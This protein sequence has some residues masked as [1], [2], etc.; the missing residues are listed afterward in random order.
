[1]DDEV[2]RLLARTRARREALNSRLKS[3]GEEE[4]EIR[5]PLK[6]KNRAVSCSE[7]STES[8][9]PFKGRIL[10]KEVTRTTEETVETRR[11]VTFAGDLD[12]ET[13][14]D[15]RTALGDDVHE[16]PVVSLQKSVVPKEK[17]VSPLFEDDKEARKKRLAGLAAKYSAWEEELPSQ[18]NATAATAPA[19]TSE[20]VD[21]DSAI[22]EAEDTASSSKVK[23]S[24]TASSSQDPSFLKSLQAQGFTESSSK[25]KLVYDFN[26]HRR[27]S[28]SLSPVK[29]Y[30]TV[31]HYLSPTRSYRSQVPT[32]SPSPSKPHPL[33][34]VSP[35]ARPPAPLAGPPKP[36]RTYATPAPEDASDTASRQT[37]HEKKML[38]ES[39]SPQKTKSS[40]DPALLSLSDRKALFERNKTAPKPIAR[41]GEAVTPAMLSKAAAA[42]TTVSAGG[43]AAWKRRTE[44]G[45]ERSKRLR[46]V[47]P[48]HPGVSRIEAQKKLFESGVK[49]GD[50]R[51]TELARATEEKKKKDMDVL[52]KR[53]IS[54]GQNEKAQKTKDVKQKEE[55]ILEELPPPPPPPIPPPSPPQE[56]MEED[57]DTLEEHAVDE[58]DD[59]SMN[60]SAETTKMEDPSSPPLP[61]PPSSK[62]HHDNY[63]GIHS[64]KKVRISPP[65]SGNMYPQF[66]ETDE[67]TL[68]RSQT[69][70]SME[71]EAASEAPSLGTAIQQAA[72]AKRPSQ[73]SLIHEDGRSKLDSSNCSED[74]DDMLDEALDDSE[75]AYSDYEPTPP[76]L[77]KKSPTTSTSSWEFESKS[78]SSSSPRK[79]FKTPLISGLTDSP[80][81]EK[82]LPSIEGV[83]DGLLHTVSFYRKREPLP[84][85]VRNEAGS[86]SQNNIFNSETEEDPEI[87]RQ[88]ILLQIRKLQEDAMQQEQR[89]EQASKALNYCVSKDEFEGSSE[90]VEGERLLLEAFHKYS[91]AGAEVERLKTEG[92]MGKST[93]QRVRSMGC[94]GSISI[95]GISLRLKT[96]FIKLLNSGLDDF[97]HYFVC[98]VKYK[99]Q[100][101]ATQ[102]LSSVDGISKG[103]LHFPNLINVREL[104]FDFQIH[105]EVY[106]LQTRKEFFTHEAKYHIRKDKSVF[107]LTPLKKLKKQESSRLPGPRNQNPVNSKTIRRPA[108]G[109][110]GHTTISLDSMKAKKYSLHDVPP[111][112]PLEK[113]LLM[114]L[115]AHS[116]NKV[117]KRGFLT[118]FTDL[119]GY[120]D[121]NRRWCLLSGNTLKFWKYPE[122]ECK[123]VP[124]YEINLSSCITENVTLAP[125]EICSRMN[126]FMFETQRPT[127]GDDKQSLIMHVNSKSGLT[128]IRHLV[129][130]DTREERIAWCCIINSA[131]VNLRAWDPS[132]RPRTDSESSSTGEAASYRYTAGSVDSAPSTTDIW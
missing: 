120:G 95:S 7:S 74:I 106:A 119:N 68:P 60:D 112:S 72:A 15:L 34:F 53:F 21:V 13:K 12:E 55:I 127:R 51:E 116:E 30:P 5:S 56:E 45:E 61:T 121:W 87:L 37:L 94:K 17:S 41:F 109:R 132:F 92:A 47:S 111:I 99:S 82:S 113:D 10:K 105:L 90:R 83:K 100:V 4:K 124:K 35:A 14:R 104:D 52:L 78:K 43:D 86:A 108:F 79:D 8:S 1:M 3:V 24:S 33:Q 129:M 49:V 58:D 27:R 122:D 59:T 28:R 46:S 110:V 65:K 32:R 48:L 128:R 6:E 31:Q 103:R 23:A 26:Q 67:D 75:L 50:W 25:S 107:N 36:A 22:Q 2:S 98:L 89:M 130:A 9:A 57:E 84:K 19:N 118:L 85:I 131:L 125:R 88:G 102:M 62:D 96:D 81:K 115:T 69:A 70:M 20:I 44:L 63:P 16:S 91:A 11:V 42:S 101:I 126:T 66:S 80:G 117:E 40:L 39:K 29:S 38:F 54:S 71:S 64:M 123:E 18:S 76:K 93:P 114:N 97:V 73:M 77:S